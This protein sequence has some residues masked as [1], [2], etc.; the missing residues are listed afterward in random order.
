MGM[1]KNFEEVDVEN[2]HFVFNLAATIVAKY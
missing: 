1:S 2:I